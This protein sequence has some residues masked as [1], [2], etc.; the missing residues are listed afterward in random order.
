MK[1]V[2]LFI[3]FVLVRIGAIA[4]SIESKNTVLAVEKAGKNKKVIYVFKPGKHLWIKTTDN[5]NLHLTTYSVFEDAIVLIPYDTIPFDEI[6]QIRG[7][8]IGNT[9]RKTLGFFISVISIPAAGMGGFIASYSSIPGVFGGLPFAGTFFG[10][11]SLM[12][13]RKFDT[14]DKWTLV[15][16][17]E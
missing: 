14:S 6:A 5:F 2:A 1:I 13:P 7:K 10:G 3:L 8:V 12:G 11:L 4:Q 9:G 15:L 17:P 16:T